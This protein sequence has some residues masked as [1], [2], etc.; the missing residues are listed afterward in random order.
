M[1]AAVQ[2]KA[3]SQ[4]S[5]GLVPFFLLTF[6]FTWTLQLAITLFRLPFSS[7]LAQ[8]LYVVSVAGPLF[9]C[10]TVLTR[11]SGFAGVKELFG[12]IRSRFSPVWYLVALLLIFAIELAAAG[13]NLAAGG[14]P[15]EHWFVAPERGLLEL[16]GQVYVMFAEELGWRGFALP[17]LQERFGSLG[18]ALILG[19]IH[20][21]WHLPMFL[22]PGAPQAHTFFPYYLFTVIFWA[23]ANTLLYSRSRG[24]V[25]PAMLFHF[26][27]NMCAFTLNTPAG[28]NLYA[29]ILYAAVLAMM[30][31][32]LPR[33]LFRRVQA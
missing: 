20:A 22:V 8:V 10:L 30:I 23:A 31:P 29:G 5:S 15:P 13:L 16:A 18:Q 14:V 19:A 17:R 7:G 28:N 27:L 1:V 6:G 9:G 3:H 32:M 26:G 21:C 11:Q 4:R 33:P 12:R 2:Q 25:L 24:S